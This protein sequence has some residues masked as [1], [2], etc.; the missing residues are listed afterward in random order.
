MAAVLLWCITVRTAVVDVLDNI[1]EE[2]SRAYT[3]VGT[4]SI[5]ANRNV[6]ENPDVYKPYLRSELDVLQAL[7]LMESERKCE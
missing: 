3:W 1:S 5:R 2:I 6:I 4:T 7:F